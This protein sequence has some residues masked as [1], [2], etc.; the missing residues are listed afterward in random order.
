MLLSVRGVN[1]RRDRQPS[2]ARHGIPR[3]HRKIEQR[4]FKVIRVNLR[5]RQVVCHVE[6]Q[7]IWVDGYGWQHRRVR[8]CD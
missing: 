7:R 6:R 2:A 4:K 1:V 8:V 5:G 3:I